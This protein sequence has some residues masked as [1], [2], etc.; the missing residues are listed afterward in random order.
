MKEDVELLPCPFCGGKAEIVVRDVEPQG[1]PWYG[2]KEERFVLCECGCCLFDKYF[3]DG[4]W[5]EDKNNPVNTTAAWNTRPQ[6]PSQDKEG[7]EIIAKLEAQEKYHLERSEKAQ[8]LCGDTAHHSP[9]Y[10]E[11]AK[12]NAIGEMLLIIRP[13]LA[14]LTPKPAEG[15]D[16]EAI[17]EFADRVYCIFQKGQIVPKWLAV[18]AKTISEQAARLY[19]SGG[20]PIAD[21]EG[22]KKSVHKHFKSTGGSDL[23]ALERSLINDV[24][25]HLASRRLIGGVDTDTLKFVKELRSAVNDLFPRNSYGMR[26]DKLEKLLGSKETIVDRMI[27]S[28]QMTKEEAESIGRPLNA[29]PDDG[30]K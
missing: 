30:A 3:H 13:Y 21:L 6:S 22:L 28:G 26:F 19:A 5:E 29:A 9:S 7:A 14:A 10:V 20:A 17:K 11:A 4:F 24:I 2:G 25:D 23:A 27:A 16:T 8:E 18:H 15:F 1:D 12:A